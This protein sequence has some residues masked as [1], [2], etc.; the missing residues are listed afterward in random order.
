MIELKLTERIS[1][2]KPVV[3]S[4]LRVESR[5]VWGRLLP[6]KI[7]THLEFRSRRVCNDKCQENRQE[8]PHERSHVVVR[9]SVNSLAC[10][11]AQKAWSR[12][13]GNGTEKWPEE[14]EEYIYM[15]RLCRQAGGVWRTFRD[16]GEFMGHVALTRWL[17]P[18]WR[19][20]FSSNTKTGLALQNFS[21]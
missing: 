13:D 2:M 21:C 3:G 5:V 11:S 18:F 7:I 10:T 8:R 14:G 1:N 16:R 20:K 4:P 9:C 12:N 19:L 6:T 15:W 17:C